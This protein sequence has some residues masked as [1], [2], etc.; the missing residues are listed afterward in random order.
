MAEEL[1]DDAQ[2][3]AAVQEMRGERMA[4]GVRADLEAEGGLLE[5]L[6]AR[7]AGRTASS[8]VRPDN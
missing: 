5:I 1:L 6:M 4:Q 8:A 3:G 2:I 7:G